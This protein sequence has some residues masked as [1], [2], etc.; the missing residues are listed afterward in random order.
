M[1]ASLLAASFV[2]FAALSLAP[3]SLIATLFG[4][5]SLPPGSTR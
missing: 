5:R 2:I 1:L 4:G 3:G